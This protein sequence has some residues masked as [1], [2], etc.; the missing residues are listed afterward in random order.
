MSCSETSGFTKKVRATLG[1]SANLYALAAFSYTTN[2]TV[3]TADANGA[4]PAIDGVTLTVG[5]SILL[6]GEPTAQHNGVWRVTSLGDGSNPW[7]LT[8]PDWMADAVEGAIV[9]V[10]SGTTYKNTL[11]TLKAFTSPILENDQTWEEVPDGYSDGGGGGGSGDVVGPASSTDNAIARFDGTT[12][13]LI[14]NSG[15]T[16]ADGATGT[17]SGTNSGDV[18][19]AGTPNYITISGQVIT[20]N[21]VNLAT[22]VT[23]TLDHGS[24]LTGLADDD[25]SQYALL[26]GRSGGQTLIGGTGS[27]DG[28]TLKGTSLYI[29]PVNIE[30]YFSLPELSTPNIPGTPSTGYGYVYVKDTTSKIYF[31][32]DAGTEYDLTNTGGAG[33]VTSVDVAVPSFLSS[34]GGPITTSGTITL[35]LA[36]QS[37]Y[38]VFNRASGTGVPVFQALS[39]G[40]IPTGS[41]P[42]TGAITQY[43]GSSAPTG[44][45]ECDGSAVSRTT[46]ANLFAAIGTT[47]GA[48]DGSTTFN[49]PSFNRRVPVGRGGSGT[50]TLGSTLGSTG[51]SETHTLTTTEMPSHNHG[52]NGATQF[53]C[54]SGAGSFGYGAGVSGAVAPTVT[55]STGGGG[56][57]NNIQP[58]LVVM[59]II[60]T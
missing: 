57:H 19:L 47:Y 40:H 45:L 42:P 33:T 27:M 21:Q 53:M 32:D 44:W 1:P 20:R 10:M 8:R 31:K 39:D 12:G 54:V 13:K 38:T 15:I 17:L 48:G 34:S 46:Y 29:S 24:Q 55:T 2:Y 25:H 52:P 14:Q 41:K 23:G 37:P 7:V 60:K 28:L 36:N 6:S 35:S 22:D 4:F 59:Y 50:G 56:S 3:I 43:G 51:G 5:E 49:L 58:S 11:W 9:L 18:T 30:S 26:A 16:I